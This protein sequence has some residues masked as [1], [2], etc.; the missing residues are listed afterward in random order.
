MAKSNRPRGLGQYRAVPRTLGSLR[1]FDD[2]FLKELGGCI[3]NWNHLH[4]L[5]CSLLQELFTFEHRQ[6]IEAMWVSSQQDAASRK[7]LKSAVSAACKLAERSSP[8]EYKLSLERFSQG[9]ETICAWAASFENKYRNPL[10]H[11]MYTVDGNVEIGFS[12]IPDSTRGQRHSIELEKRAASKGLAELAA[13]ARK[14]TSL[15][16]KYA[17]ALVTAFRLSRTGQVAEWPEFPNVRK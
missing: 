4:N 12:F 7:L 17:R 6:L 13:T 14:E 10:V 9:I 3:V 16:S 11:A 5:L 2:R 1:A 15:V 8:H